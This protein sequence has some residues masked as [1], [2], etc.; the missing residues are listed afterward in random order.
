LEKARN[1]GVNIIFE[2]IN[3]RSTTDPSKNAK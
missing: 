1:I 3:P 2:K